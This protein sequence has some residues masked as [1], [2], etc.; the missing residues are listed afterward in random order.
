VADDCGFCNRIALKKLVTS[1]GKKENMP[2]Q[3]WPGAA[4]NGY[5]HSSPKFRP[6]IV[7]IATIFAF[8]RTLVT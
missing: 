2:M 3:R 6:K 8:S 5:G 7:S 1:L 4:N